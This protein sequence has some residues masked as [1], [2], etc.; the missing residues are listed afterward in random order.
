MADVSIGLAAISAYGILLVVNNQIPAM[1]EKHPNKPEPP[2]RYF[3]KYSFMLLFVTY[4]GLNLAFAQI[5]Q[6]IWE[7]GI[8]RDVE[9]THQWVETS[10]IFP[11]VVPQLYAYF[12]ILPVRDLYKF[13][14]AVLLALVMGYIVDFY[15]IISVNPLT[16]EMSLRYTFSMALILI[17]WYFLL[18]KYRL[19]SEARRGR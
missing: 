1:V 9:S 14:F 11:V 17:V 7:S 4:I 18:I 8:F 10:L 3:I 6:Y 15:I 12:K 2:N 19:K 13:E 5:F 16:N